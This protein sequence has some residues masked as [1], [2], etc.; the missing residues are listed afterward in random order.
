[1]TVKW[2]LF[3]SYGYGRRLL[4][5]LFVLYVICEMS[6]LFKD[7]R[8]L[9]LPFSEGE[10]RSCK[11]CVGAFTYDTEQQD[12]AGMGTQEAISAAP[13]I[14]SIFHTYSFPKIDIFMMKYITATLLY[15]S[16]L[17]AIQW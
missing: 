3:R 7:N 8:Y 10:I 14:P 17:R 4:K 13:L 2:K 11:C 9:S 5:L 1:M 12:K 6:F 15:S 16:L